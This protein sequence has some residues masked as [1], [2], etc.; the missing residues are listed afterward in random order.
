M[1]YGHK[2][3]QLHA[4][5]FFMRFVRLFIKAHLSRRLRTGR[6]YMQMAAVNWCW[7]KAGPDLHYMNIC[8]H[9]LRTCCSSCK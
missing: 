3:A 1:C 6:I 9:T 8:R 7:C 2:R 4:E 5:V